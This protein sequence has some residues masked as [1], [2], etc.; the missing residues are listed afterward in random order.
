VNQIYRRAVIRSRGFC[1][2]LRIDNENYNKRLASRHSLCVITVIILL[3]FEVVR[4]FPPIR[5]AARV[6]SN[7]LNSTVPKKHIYSVNVRNCV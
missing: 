1:I 7:C 3:L 6:N 2:I 5:P 4:R